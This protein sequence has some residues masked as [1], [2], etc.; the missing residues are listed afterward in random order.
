[1]IS[2]L[3]SLKNRAINRAANW[4]CRGS[5][6]KDQERV[7]RKNIKMDYMAGVDDTMRM[8]KELIVPV[9]QEYACKEQENGPARIACKELEV[10]VR[11]PE[12]HHEIAEIHL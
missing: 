7:I 3:K 6:P 11:A 2:I 12:P 4:S 8:I 1:M 10:F 5:L 9:L